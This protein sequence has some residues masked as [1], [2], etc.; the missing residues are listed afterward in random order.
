MA[1]KISTRTVVEGG[2]LKTPWI[3]DITPVQGAEVGA[4]FI[5]LSASDWNIKKFSGLNLKGKLEK[6]ELFTALRKLRQ[7]ALNDAI[8]AHLKSTNDAYKKLAK[9][10]SGIAHEFDLG[11]I[12]SCVSGSLPP[13]EHAGEKAPKTTFTMQVQKIWKKTIVIQLTPEAL[14]YVRIAFRKHVAERNED[15][16]RGKRS[17][18]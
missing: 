10:P 16:E 7:E 6:A 3:V 1:V 14:H 18:R 2:N 15:P 12:G 17:R 11:K 5:Q 13:I 8:L 4:N 9:L